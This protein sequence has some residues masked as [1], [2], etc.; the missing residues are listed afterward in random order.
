MSRPNL[1]QAAAN[2]DY[3]EDENLHFLPADHPLMIRLQTALKENLEKD[4][5]RVHLQ[6]KEK[7]NK[8]KKIERER[9]VCFLFSILKGDYKINRLPKSEL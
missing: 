4:H 6:L 8:I 5:E 9:V 1:D 7:E 3:Y 2:D